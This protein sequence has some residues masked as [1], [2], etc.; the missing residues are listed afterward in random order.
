MTSIDR[1]GFVGSLVGALVAPGTV[2]SRLQV[3]AGPR[4]VITHYRPV[5]EIIDFVRYGIQMGF[6]EVRHAAGMFGGLVEYRDVTCCGSPPNRGPRPAVTATRDAI[7]IVIP[8]L[9]SGEL[10]THVIASAKLAGALVFNANARNIEPYKTCHSHV[11]HVKPSAETLRAARASMP[12]GVSGEMELWTH[13]LAR[14]GA[15]TLNRRYR[16][17]SARMDSEIWGGWFAVKCAWEAALKSKATTATELI[18]YLESPD[19][20]FDGHKGVPLSFDASHELV[21]PLY[22]VDRGVVN[23]EADP[24]VFSSAS[25]P[26]CR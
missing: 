8:A 19:A 2:L 25:R 23:G 13:T 5:E 15:D 14:F 3:P 4:L 20:R 24:S 9:I 12:A 1:R 17:P 16:G 6:E 18:A 26:T 22:L 21:Q 11:F 7:Q 10:M